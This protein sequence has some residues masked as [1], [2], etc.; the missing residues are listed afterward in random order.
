MQKR[1]RSERDRQCCQIGGVCGSLHSSSFLRSVLKL[2]A[3]VAIKLFLLGAR[4]SV[5][6]ASVDPPRLGSIVARGKGYFTL[7]FLPC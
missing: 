1:Y 3:N 5:I 6:I 7:L 4:V 2:I